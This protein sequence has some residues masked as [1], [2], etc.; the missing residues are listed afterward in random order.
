[1]SMFSELR[2]RAVGDPKNIVFDPQLNNGLRTVIYLAVEEGRREDAYHA[3]AISVSEQ[4]LPKLI[5]DVSKSENVALFV[6]AELNSH[7]VAADFKIPRIG[8]GS[9]M[10]DEL[11][12][13]SD[14]DQTKKAFDRICSAVADATG[15]LIVLHEKGEVAK[16]GDTGGG[17][18]RGSAR[19]GRGG[20]AAKGEGRAAKGDR[21][22]R[23]AKGE[24]KPRA[25][26]G[27]GRT[28][29]TDAERKAK[30]KARREARKKAAAKG[31]R[32]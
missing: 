28:K 20:R 1:M 21:K 3:V 24:R 9:D 13:M 19:S 17:E 14:K 26:K 11:K 22:P 4:S 25:A 8:Y 6:T 23:A 16:P 5:K 18:R 12:K 30:R 27:G 2:T 31:G 29:L 32:K 10:W 7:E 15:R